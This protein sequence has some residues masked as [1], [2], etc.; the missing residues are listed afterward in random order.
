V[1]SGSIF[2]TRFIQ[3]VTT[4]QFPQIFRSSSPFVS[5]DTDVA[6]DSGRPY[7]LRVWLLKEFVDRLA[8]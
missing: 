5:V 4:S 1:S 3:T 8:I 6:D 7:T 2:Q